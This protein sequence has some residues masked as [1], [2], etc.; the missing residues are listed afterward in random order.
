MAELTEAQTEQAIWLLQE[1]ITALELALQDSDWQRLTAD[2]EREFSRQGLRAI[3]RLARLMFLKNPLIGRGVKVKAFYVFGQGVSVRAAQDEFQQV[4][5]AFWDDDK[6]QDEMTGH[7]SLTAKERE[8]E[9][10]GNLFLVFFTDQ[11]TG[12]VR[13]RS[14]PF[15]DVDDIICNPEDS[16]DPWYYR[17]VWTEQ[18]TDIAT[19]AQSSVQRTAYYPDWRYNPA[20]KPERIGPHEVRWSTPVCHKKVGG[21]GDWKFGLSEVYAAIDWAKAYKEF[22]EDWATIVRAY[23]RFAFELST[24]GGARGIAAAKSKLGTTLGLSSGETNPAPL[25]GS[26]FVAGEGTSLQPVRT[27]GAT[28][29]IDDARRLLLMVA[30]AVGLPETFFGDVSVGTLATAKSLDRPTELAMMDRQTFWS[31][32]L[33]DIL[34][35]AFRWAVKAPQGRLRQMGRLVVKAQGDELIERVEWNDDANPHID[36]DFPP[37][38]TRDAKDEVAAI[39]SAATL[40]GKANAGILNEQDIVRML[41]VALGENDI[42]ELMAA[43][44]DDQGQ[45]LGPDGKPLPTPADNAADGMTEAVR[46]L[47]DSLVSLREKY[48][49]GQ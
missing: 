48:E 17:R 4:I 33:N 38:I 21:F 29:G 12:D 39:V 49:P 1:Q 24:K 22:L 46:E 34:N 45:R 31:G 9:I 44:Y 23:R 30:A 10:D 2:G 19:G 35:Y 32:L 11:I 7:Q 5:E 27:A 3:T 37:L 20:A 36:I 8:I 6:N 28:V 16:K 43:M 41:L 42:D 18:K 40:D 15:D 25:V 14:I 13:L 47:R 26:T